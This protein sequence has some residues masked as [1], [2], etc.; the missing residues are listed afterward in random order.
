M[1]SNDRVEQAVELLKRLI[2]IPSL[3]FQ[4]QGVADFVFVHLQ[5]RVETEGVGVEIERI[6]N[7][8]VCYLPSSQCDAKTLMLVAHMDTVPASDGYSRDPFTPFCEGD[9]I[10]GL[11]S[12]DDGGSVVSMVETLFHFAKSGESKLNIILALSAEEERSGV[13]GIEIVIPELKFRPD[14]VIVGE[15]TQMKAAVA[16]RGLLV[17]DCEAEGVSGH[18]A[19]SEGVNALYIAMDDIA[20]MRNFHFDRVSELMGEVKLTVTQINCGT[21]HNVVPD[22]ARFVVDIRPTEL[23][24]NSEIVELL[25]CEVKSRITP[26]NLKNR[27]SATPSSGALMAAINS[28]G[29]DTY[30]SPTTSDWVRLPQFEAVKMGAGDSSRSHRADEYI[31]RTEI[32]DAVEGY[33]KFIKTVATY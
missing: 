24:T 19:R 6:G 33:I 18:A 22:R 17:L 13:N 23:Y 15:P 8:I 10:Y 2:A 28:L 29:I 1:D 32:A 16:E 20:T 25:Q 4:E 21:E 14:Y 11:G 9:R 12:N 5:N 26:R 30:I 27:A 3:T 31:T 7:N